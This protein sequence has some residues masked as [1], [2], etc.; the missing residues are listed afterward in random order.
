MNSIITYLYTPNLKGVTID[1]R[2]ANTMSLYYTPRVKLYK[3]V[4]QTI[5]LEF[6]NRDNKTVSVLGKTVEF[7]VTDKEAGTTLLRKTVDYVDAQRGTGS[8]R[9][10]SNDLINLP[11][12]FYTYALKITDAENVENPV[13]T[14][15]SYGCAGTLE[16]TDGVY[17]TFVPSYTENFATGHIGSTIFI[18]ESENRNSA[19]HTAQVFFDSSFTGTLDIQVS[20]S[21]STESLDTTDFYT[22]K[23]LNYTDQTQSDIVSFQGIY[24]AIRFVRSTSGISQ[25]LYRP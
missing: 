10:E 15:D 9:F 14:D 5:R 23:T 6:R 25:V 1:E 3:G 22:L 19:L 24:S 20:L 21:A 18:N 17:P 7:I 4:G 2:V 16:L 12:K 13:F 11:S 8:I